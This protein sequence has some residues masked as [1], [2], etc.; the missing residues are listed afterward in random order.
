MKL[1]TPNEGP[2]DRMIRLVI[3]IV[4]IG[5][6]FFS[7]NGYLQIGAYVAGVVS[8]A[9]GITGFCGLY[10]LLGTNTCPRK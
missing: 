1:I 6:A 2:L 3:G 4:L 7:L 10:T 9:T 5:A 8:L